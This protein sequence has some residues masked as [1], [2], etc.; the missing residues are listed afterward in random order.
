[1]QLFLFCLLLVSDISAQNYYRYC[2]ETDETRKVL[3]GDHLDY[4]IIYQDTLSKEYYH[5]ITHGPHVTYTANLVFKK[6]RIIIPYKNYQYDSFSLASICFN[7]K[8]LPDYHHKKILLYEGKSN[9]QLLSDCSEYNPNIN[10]V[11]SPKCQTYYTIFRTGWRFS[12]CSGK[13]CNN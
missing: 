7:R 1:M 8:Q 11:L 4:T 5:N 6:D 13:I 10:D 3:P 12:I 9:Y 2:V